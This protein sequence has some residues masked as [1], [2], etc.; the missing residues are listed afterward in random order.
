MRI[1]QI[2]LQ[3]GLFGLDLGTSR[4]SR[5]E[6][7]VVLAGRNGSGKTRILRS[8]SGLLTHVSPAQMGEH[9]ASQLGSITVQVEQLRMGIETTTDLERR[10]LLRKTLATRVRDAEANRAGCAA[11]ASLELQGEW[12]ENAVSLYLKDSYS[13]DDPREMSQ[14]VLKNRVDQMEQL[15]LGRMSGSAPAYLTQVLKHGHLAQDHSVK[16]D[17]EE[18]SYRLESLE[19]MQKMLRELLGV[20]MGRDQDGDPTLFGL[21]LGNARLSQ[22]QI[23]LLMLAVALHAQGG[24]Y[25]SRILLLDEPERHLHPDALIQVLDRL[26][27]FIQDGQIWIA[28]HSVHILAWAPADAIWYV[29]AGRATW[30]GRTP[31]RVLEGL[32]GGDQRRAD[33]EQFLQLPAQLAATRF[34]AECLRPPGVVQTGP[35]DRQ[36]LQVRSVVSRLRGLGRPLRI[37]DFGAGR[38]RLL[39]ALKEE[40]G[41]NEDFT[42]DIDYRAFDPSEEYREHRLSTIRDL[43]GSESTT[44]DFQRMDALHADLDGQVDLVVLCNVLH[45]IPPGRWIALF[46]DLSRLL[47]SEGALLVV[48]DHH[49]P[50]GERAHEFGFLILDDPQ[51]K[52]LLGWKSDDPPITTV[53][54]ARG[55]L[56]A[57]LVPASLLERVSSATRAAALRSLK[58]RAT[59][60]LRSLYGSSD[61]SFAAGQRQALWSQLLANATIALDDHPA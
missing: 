56:K 11:I 6:K 48:E 9:F 50:T 23:V 27:H 54:D 20:E 29:E 45:E 42:S 17:D 14:S 37:L 18:R 31:E 49:I 5:L 58:D 7:I 19:R 35:E 8:V 38:A 10:R 32:L 53:A 25:R 34:A 28:T 16:M 40:V 44:R 59:E 4:F 47:T 22:G 12:T 52:A 15:G 2:E 3:E 21:P 13:L 26:A 55:R 36:L 61:K 46:S 24:D 1:V 43:Y 60:E 57:H 30:A 51:L 39:P 41:A 33:L